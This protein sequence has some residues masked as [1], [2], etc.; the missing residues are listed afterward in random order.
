MKISMYQMK[1]FR[2]YKAINA[3]FL[4]GKTPLKSLQINYNK[5]SMHCASFS[6][7]CFSKSDKDYYA[8]KENV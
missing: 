2:H 8:C 4:K 5:C 6:S 3:F 1:G 7:F